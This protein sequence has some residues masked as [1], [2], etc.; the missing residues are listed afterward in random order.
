M[1]Q[2]DIK[3]YLNFL[4]IKENEQKAHAHEDRSQ[5]WHDIQIVNI[6]CKVSLSLFGYK[7]GSEMISVGPFFLF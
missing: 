2:N 3:L 1:P 7:I 4:I 6:S 5:E